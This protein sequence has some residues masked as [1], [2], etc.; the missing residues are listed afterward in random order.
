MPHRQSSRPPN[1]AEVEPGHASEAIAQTMIEANQRWLALQLEVMEAAL[2]DNARH[3]KALLGQGTAPADAFAA[4]PRLYADAM[5]RHNELTKS[6]LELATQTF[7]QV[8]RLLGQMLAA[9]L[10]GL[11]NMTAA[12]REAEEGFVERRVAA[13]I[14]N[15]P[16]RRQA[17]PT[18]GGHAGR[19]RKA[20]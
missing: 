7:V 11:G 18:A 9:S 15:F 6:G 3:S 17:A 1:P 8:N 16:D 12:E 4:W 20:A 19:Q 2:A 5:R 13:R 10:A 14:I